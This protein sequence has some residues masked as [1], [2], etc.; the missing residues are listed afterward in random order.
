MGVIFSVSDLIIAVEGSELSKN[1]HHR[2]QGQPSKFSN[3]RPLVPD[4]AL[5]LLWCNRSHVFAPRWTIEDRLLGS[6]RRWR[7][8]PCDIPPTL[9]PISSSDV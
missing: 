2:S 6:R 3:S 5:L 9:L 1:R 7:A 8:T 4:T